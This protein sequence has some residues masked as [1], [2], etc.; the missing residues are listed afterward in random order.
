MDAPSG[1][2]V[3]RVPLSIRQSSSISTT[4]KAQIRERAKRPQLSCNPCRQRK[5]KVRSLEVS[6]VQTIKANWWQCDRVQPCTACSLHQTADTCDYDLTESERRP[7]LQAEALKEKDKKIER[8]QE[9]IQML[10]GRS[11]KSEQ[12]EEDSIFPRSESE[13]QHQQRAIR[14]TLTHQ[15]LQNDA[16]DNNIYFGC[17]SMAAV[18]QEVFRFYSPGERR[19]S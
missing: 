19:S 9:E 10:Q 16:F 8:L 5:V 4:T 6:Y 12:I 15:G 17:P 1:S 11:F 13:I 14:P 2:A 3:A 7:I 18:A